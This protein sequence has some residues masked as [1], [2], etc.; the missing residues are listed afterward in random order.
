MHVL[1]SIFMDIPDCLKNMAK[2]S[3]TIEPYKYGSVLQWQA[4]HFLE[5]KG[6]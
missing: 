5:S 6:R 1:I 4:F 2:R 3:M